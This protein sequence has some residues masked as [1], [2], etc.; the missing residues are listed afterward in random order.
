MSGL[1]VIDSYDIVR[2]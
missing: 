2:K 1:N